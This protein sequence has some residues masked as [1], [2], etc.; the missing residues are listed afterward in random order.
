MLGITNN[1]LRKLRLNG[2]FKQGFHYRDTSI[3]NSGLPRWQWHVERCTQALESPL[4]RRRGYYS[5]I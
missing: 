5:R 2:L 1:Q 3:P 4:E